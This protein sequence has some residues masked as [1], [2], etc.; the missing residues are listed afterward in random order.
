[1]VEGLTLGCIGSLGQHF[2]VKCDFGIGISQSPSLELRCPF[3]IMLLFLLTTNSFLS[4]VMSHPSSHNWS[5]DMRLELFKAGSTI[6]FCA[7]SE[8]RRDKDRIP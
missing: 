7:L 5:M 2:V 4:I 6:V 1:M 3:K 8:R